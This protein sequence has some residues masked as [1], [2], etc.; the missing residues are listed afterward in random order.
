MDSLIIKW[1]N[2]VLE[3]IEEIE[4]FFENRPKR[5][6]DFTKDRVLKKA[7]LMNIL[8]IGEAVNRIL[9]VK[10]DIEITSARKIVNTRNYVIHG[11]DSLQDDII[12]SIVIKHLPILKQDVVKL[13][14]SGR[15]TNC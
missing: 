11:Y 13:L 1:S 14:D 15:I 5:F 7:I 9:K 3:A 2:D 4:F 10:P 12:W 6:N 8:I